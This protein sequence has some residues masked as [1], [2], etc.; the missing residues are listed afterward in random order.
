MFGIRKR[1]QR[2]RAWQDAAGS[3]GLQVVDVSGWNPRVKAR[4]G[5]VE[6]WIEA[7]GKK[8][9]STRVVVVVPGPPDF[10]TVKIRPE[11]PFRW[12]QE[13]E[14][15]D[16][17][18]DSTYLIEGPMRLVCALLDAEARRLL[19]SINAESQ[20]IEIADGELRVV[21]FGSYVSEILPL[22]LK[23][24]QRFAQPVD[25][26]RRLAENAQKDPEA[27]VRLQNLLLLIHE[28]PGDPGTVEV[29]RTACL[30]PSPKIRLRAAKE[31]GVEGR[32]ILL[33]LAENIEDDSVSA[34]AVPALDRELPFERTRAILERALDGRH[35]QT[36]HACLEALG[37]SG[38]AA[39]VDMLAKV[40][41]QEKGE[42]ATA[43]AQALGA[44]GNPAAEP[45]LILALQSE[46][47]DLRVAA[48]DALGRVGS[49]ESVLPL[50][51]AAERSWIDRELRRAARQ[52][53]AGIQ[54]RLQGASPGQLS[55]AGAEAG[56]LSLA[57]A[58]AGQLSLANDTDGQLSLPDPEEGVKD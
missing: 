38:A 40:M 49:V 48:A 33:E 3:C 50:K 16:Q 19:V 13:I 5:P 58:E 21:R 18:F 37:R 6:V 39:A 22:L 57:E 20:W 45:S 2:L 28:L 17:P 7:C 34:E 43:A 27:G 4:A 9:H 56:Q 24:A 11:P 32:P 12:K 25:V 15:G 47:A 23:L 53:I 26:P 30:D 52:A 51:Q 54:S 8:E 55:L 41:E 14:I 36:A 42:L 1:F 10:R 29:L 46:S 44:L 35:T 31:L